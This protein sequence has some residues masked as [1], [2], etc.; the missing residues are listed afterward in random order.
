METTVTTDTVE[1]LRAC[2][3]GAKMGIESIDDV[4]RYVRDKSMRDLL[5]G[6]RR[7]HAKLYADNERLLDELGESG[8][9]PNPVAKGMSQIKVGVK[10]AMDSSDATIA[11]LLTD[12]CNMGIKSIWRYRNQYPNAA[13]LALRLSGDLVDSEEQLISGLRKYL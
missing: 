6:C 7:T 13:P 10:L 3:A 11:D 1:L 9:E 4:M 2:S 5:D 12:G 8:K